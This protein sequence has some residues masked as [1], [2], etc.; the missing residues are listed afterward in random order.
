M[1]LS[2]EPRRAV[3]MPC[4]APKC[5][6][7]KQNCRITN[8]IHSARRVSQ[9]FVSS[10]NRIAGTS[11]LRVLHP[12]CSTTTSGLLQSSGSRRL[13]GP[14]IAAAA[15]LVRV[16]PPK[17]PAYSGFESRA[18]CGQRDRRRP[19]PRLGRGSRP[20]AGLLRLP[21]IA[22][23]K[24]C[25]DSAA[26]PDHQNCGRRNFGQPQPPKSR[27]TQASRERIAEPHTMTLRSSLATQNCGRRNF[28]QGRAAQG[29]AYS[30]LPRS[31]R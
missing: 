16:E 10:I 18:R 6:D 1:A 23:L 30:G 11:V 25:P 4:Q 3:A 14:K 26:P 8:D 27:P 28:G 7:E 12:L 29:P 17:E 22:L 5:I 13:P 31:H 24:P 9:D 2:F 21:E 19:V 15:I 20:R